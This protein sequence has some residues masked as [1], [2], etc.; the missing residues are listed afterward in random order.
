MPNV[1]E[2]V[3]TN[4]FFEGNRVEQGGDVYVPSEK[5]YPHIHIGD[6]FVVYSKSPSNHSYLL[7]GSE[8]FKG[9]VETAQQDC[10]EAH[11][12]QICRYLSSQY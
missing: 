5:K 10:G 4:D 8:V 2:W 9:R 1:R 11:I 12:M 7:N 6:N 3:R